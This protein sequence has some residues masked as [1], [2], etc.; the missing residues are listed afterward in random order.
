MPA[1]KPVI[2]LPTYNEADNLLQLFRSIQKLGIP[3]IVF[4]GGSTDGT[5]EIAEKNAIP[6][7][8]RKGRGKGAGVEEAL[9][10]ARNKG[11]DV[12]VLIDCDQTYPA[13][14]I[15]DLLKP[16]PK[17]DMVVGARNMKDITLLRRLANYFMTGLINLLFNGNLKDIASG[18]RALKVAKFT[19]KY[20][21]KG[22][23]IEPELSMIAL[24]E[25]MHIQE[26]S[27]PYFR[28]I[29]KSKVNVWVLFEA[30]WFIISSRLRDFRR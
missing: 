21:S 25:G 12:L 28:R 9:E 18:L 17:A 13:D 19:R 11:H 23:T 24:N 2:V 27:I 10:Y 6:L 5:I 3:V 15:P 14:R 4:D 29:G 8:R 16:F 7:I 20:R 30:T 22:F 1:E 26:F